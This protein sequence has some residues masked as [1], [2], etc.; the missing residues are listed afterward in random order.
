MCFGD[1]NVL[2]L[3]FLVILIQGIKG[4]Q[5]LRDTEQGASKTNY[6]FSL[7]YL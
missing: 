5:L 1:K 4:V 6:E 7:I 3:L 2:L